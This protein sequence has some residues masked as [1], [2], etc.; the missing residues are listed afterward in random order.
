MAAYLES[1]VRRFGIPVETD[2]RVER[3]SRNGE[4]FVATAGDRRFEADNVV[5]AMSSWQKPPSWAP[6]SSTRSHRS[7]STVWDETLLTSPMR[8]RPDAG[9]ADPIEPCTATSRKDRSLPNRK[10]RSVMRELTRLPH[11]TH[12]SASVPGRMG[13]SSCAP[14]SQ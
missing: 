7:K 5:I 9:K 4:L 6:S 11:P 2:V 14:R 8:L 10:P 12:I 3:L 13:S 1:Y